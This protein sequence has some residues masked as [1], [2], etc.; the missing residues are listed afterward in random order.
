MVLLGVD[1][2]TGVVDPFTRAERP[3][4]SQEDDDVVGGAVVVVVGGAIRC[5]DETTAV[6]GIPCLAPV[7][8]LLGVRYTK[9]PCSSS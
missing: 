4:Q 7:E 8:L 1:S 3:H 6:D 5:E 2:V 9:E